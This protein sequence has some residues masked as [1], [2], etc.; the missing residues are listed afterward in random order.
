MLVQSAINN[1]QPH[2]IKPLF[3]VER[4]FFIHLA[5]LNNSHQIKSSLI[6][7]LPVKIYLLQMDQETST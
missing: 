1:E 3:G 7:C 4:L 5:N 2:K 6:V